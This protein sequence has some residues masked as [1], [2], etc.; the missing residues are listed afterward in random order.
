MIACNVLASG[1]KGN[2]VLLNGSILIDCGVPYK[3]IQPHIQDLRL[4]LLTHRHGDHI[5]KS[6]IKRISEERPMVRFIC[7][8]FLFRILIEE[9]AVSE[10]RIDI[11]GEKPILFEDCSI[12][13][14]PLYHDVPNIGYKIYM[15]GAKVFYATD[16]GSLLGIEAKNFDLYLIEANHSEPEINEKIAE[17]L[18]NGQFSYEERARRFHLSAEQAERWLYENASIGKSKVVLLHR[19]A[20][21]VREQ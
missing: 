21:E 1:S 11:I 14:I 2:A 13:S 12:V 8:N 3:L 17:K 15:A 7:G 18:S 20:G 10:R 6:T 16:T 19:H 4:V 5:R 9:C